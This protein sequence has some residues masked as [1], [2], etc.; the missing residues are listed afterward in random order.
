MMSFFM[1]TDHNSWKVYLSIADDA[2]RPDFLIHASIM[3]MSTFSL[4]NK[5]TPFSEKLSIF[6]GMGFF[7]HC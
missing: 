6:E 3:I 1:K 2:T 4:K 7:Q 5:Q